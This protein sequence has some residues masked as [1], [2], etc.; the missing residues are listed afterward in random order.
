M[1]IKFK[2]DVLHS[3]LSYKKP[4]QM[5]IETV[6]SLFKYLNRFKSY[7]QL[8]GSKIEWFLTI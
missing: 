8:S 4:G 5:R 6:F 3:Y 2:T 1:K 7:A